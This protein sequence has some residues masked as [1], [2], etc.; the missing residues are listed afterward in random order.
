MPRLGLGQ[1]LTGGAIAEQLLVNTYGVSV[2]GTNDQVDIAY[3]SSLKPLTY[4]TVAGWA[5]PTAHQNWSKLACFA[6]ASSGWSAPYSAWSLTLDNGSVGDGKPMWE[7]ATPDTE[8]FSGKNF[9]TGGNAWIRITSDTALNTDEWSHIAATYDGSDAKL[10]VNGSETA[11]G[12]RT[13]AIHY[14]ANESV[15]LGG[16][17][18]YQNQDMYAGYLDEVAIWDVALSAADITAIYN[19]G[20]PNDLTSGSSY[21]TDRS[22]DLQGWWRFEENTGSTVADSSA[23]SNTGTLKNGAAFIENVPS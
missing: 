4:M 23:N 9:G 3:N 18:D 16:G 5:Y 2:D 11:T 20:L 15:T 22:G 17:A 12:S 7:M 6:W 13:G 8:D 19:S 21:D 14:N 10:Y 1:S